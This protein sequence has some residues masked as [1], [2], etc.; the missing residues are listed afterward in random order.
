MRVLG[1]GSAL[2]GPAVETAALISTVEERFGIAIAR[3]GMGIARRLGIRTRH[4]CRDFAMRREV[5]RAGHSNPELAARALEGALAQARLR[6]RD[7]CYI[8]GH[9]AT[10]HR[11]MPPN[12]AFVAERLGFDGPYMELRQ[13]CTG[14]ANALVVAQGLVSAGPVAIVGSETGSV[15]LDP[16]RAAEDTGQ[17][18]NLLQMGDGAA[19]I[20][21]SA[22]DG[23]PGAYLAHVYFGQS[24]AL[25]PPGLTLVAGSSRPFLDNGMLEFMHDFVAVRDQGPA[26]FESG[27]EAAASMGAGV[28]GADFILPHQANGRLAGALAARLGIAPERIAINADRVGNTGSAAIWLALAELRPH[29]PAGATVLALGAEATKHMF[30]GFRYVHA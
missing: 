28:D 27:A 13:A 4:F 12:V 26:L 5:P 23:E 2:P 1:M 24:G 19:A 6:P 20:I 17:L 25:K 16:L 30:G 10:P 22:A 14:F 18:V 8:I 21:L 9:T 29:L 3:K 7:L 15:H 11:L